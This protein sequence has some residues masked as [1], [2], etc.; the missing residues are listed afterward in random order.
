[1]N[2]SL[3]AVVF[4]SGGA[5]GA[6]AGYKFAERHMMAEFEEAIEIETTAIAKRFAARQQYA[7]PQEAVEALAT[8][9]VEIPQVLKDK[10]N[11][12]AGTKKEPT[13]YHLIKP[14]TV[15]HEAPVE[16]AKPEPIVE[17]NIFD[18]A[19]EPPEVFVIPLLEWEHGASENQK[20]NMHYYEE[21]KILADFDDQIYKNPEEVV[22]DALDRFGEQSGDP[23]AV[24][25]R[26]TRTDIDYEIVRDPGSYWRSRHGM[27][28]ADA[29]PSG[30]EG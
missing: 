8:T 10:L 7:S 4:L 1:M 30:R 28:P 2:K 14:S 15:E 23:D 12:Y 27:E 21:D 5:I 3:F 25:V 16:E 6:F 11:E 24:Y 9:A 26:N 29:P 19:V 17:E 20:I 13:A 22:G 18:K